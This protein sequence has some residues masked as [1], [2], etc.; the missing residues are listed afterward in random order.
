[1]NLN[2]Q[3]IYMLLISMMTSLTLSPLGNIVIM[4]SLS[5]AKLINVSDFLMPKSSNDLIMFS[6][7][8]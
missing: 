6:F 2:M 5:R 1:M 7:K 4:T 3:S 8:S